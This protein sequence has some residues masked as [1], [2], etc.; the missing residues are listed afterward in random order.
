MLKSIIKFSTTY[1][2]RAEWIKWVM[3]IREIDNLMHMKEPPDKA[4]MLWTL[5]KVQA[6]SYF[7]HHLR[8]SLEAEDSEVLDNELI[9]LALRDVG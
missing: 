9:E 5:L 8:M 1:Y 2:D 4:R 7:E 3:S 6:L